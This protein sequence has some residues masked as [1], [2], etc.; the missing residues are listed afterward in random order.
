MGNGFKI[1]SMDIMK[2]DVYD[3]Y[4]PAA[5]QGDPF[6]AK[7]CGKYFELVDDI[8]KAVKYYKMYLTAI[9]DDMY[10]KMKVKSLNALRIKKGLFG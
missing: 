9:D 7:E 5:E 1:H 4:I 10:I 3:K 2:A 6:A 8:D